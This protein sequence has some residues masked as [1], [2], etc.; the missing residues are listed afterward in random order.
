MTNTYSPYQVDLERLLLVK[1]DWD[2]FANKFIKLS[3]NV[4]DVMISSATAYYLEF[5][6]KNFDLNQ[7]QSSNLS[8]IV[9]DILL[10]DEFIGDFPVLISSRLQIDKTV[11]GQIAGKIVGV[12]FAPAIEDIKNTQKEK[13]KDRI[14][15][16]KSNQTRQPPPNVSTEGNVINLRNRPAA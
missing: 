15:Q 11:A 4:K 3:V 12:L 14:V 8:R 13:F 6:S 5:I 10:A 16:T 2:I 9:R 1:K 7:N